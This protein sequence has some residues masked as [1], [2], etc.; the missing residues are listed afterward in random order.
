MTGQPV[1][2][3]PPR[4]PELDADYEIVRE[5]GRGGTAVVYLARERGPGREVAIKVIR[6]TYVEDEE[7]RARLLREA[8]T[9]AALEHPNV[10][11]LYGTRHLRDGSIA[12]VMQ[13]VPGF[14]LRSELRRRGA[15]PIDMARGIATDLCRALVHAHAHR[16]VHR[17]VKPE[18]VYVDE[19]TGSARLSDFGIARTWGAESNLT[20]PGTAIGTPAYMSPE[21]IDGGVLDGRSDIYSLGLLAYEM[22]TGQAP[23]AGESLF[24]AIYKQKHEDLPAI[25]RLR[26]ETPAEL[27]AAIERALQKD[28][29]SRW[30]NAEE[31]LAALDGS[32]AVVSAA[33]AAAST[34]RRAGGSRRKRR[35]RRSG[36][37][38]TTRSQAAPSGAPAA[39]APANEAPT[40]E[41]TAGGAPAG[42]APGN[43]APG[44]RKAPG[45]KKTSRDATAGVLPVPQP[46]HDLQ[47]DPEENLTVWYRRPQAPAEP[48]H[49]SAPA[50]P[51]HES[52][53]APPTRSTPATSPAAAARARS[54]PP[55][56]QPASP[57]AERAPAAAQ[58]S[59]VKGVRFA[60]LRA[61]A[62]PERRAVAA[63]AAVLAAAMAASPAMVSFGRWHPGPASAEQTA[64][65]AALQPGLPAAAQ[66]AAGPPGA[67]A[68]AY[69]V[70]GDGQAGPVG[71]TLSDPLVLRVEDASG[72]PV[73]GAT[74]RFSVVTG[75]AV[76]EPRTAITDE[77]GV[78]MARWLPA[79]PGRHAV[80]ATVDGYDGAPATF[81]AT[82]FAG[83]SLRISAAAD[84]E[85]RGA[86]GEQV[87]PPLQVRVADERGEPVAGVPVRFSVVRGDGR[88]T[89]DVEV[90][91]ADGIARAAWV[92]GSAAAQ[93]ATASLRD[94]PGEQVVF[95][96]AASGGALAVRSGFALGG[97][98]T[99]ALDGRGV[100]VCWGGNDNGQLGDGSGARRAQPVQVSA[101][102]RFAVLAAGVSHTCAIGVS[103]A[104][105]CWGS[106]AAGQLGDGTRTGSSGPARV[107]LAEPLAG[108]FAG[109]S[110]SCGLQE[111]GRLYCWGQ[112]AHGQLGDG[113]RTDR[114]T[115]VR[116]GRGGVFRTAALGWAHTCALTPAGAAFC[117]GRNTS[118]ELGDGRSPDR[119]E[120]APVAGDHRFT[121]IAAGSAHTCALRTD[122][123]VLC[124]GQNSHGQ[125]GNGTTAN[126]AVPVRVQ[127][128]ERF[129]AVAA[130]GVHSCALTRSGEVRC[131]G[132]NVYGQL[133]DGTNQDRHQPVAVEGVSGLTTLDAS[134]AHTCAS[135]GGARYCWGF[136]LAGQLGDGTRANQN[137][138]VRQR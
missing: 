100:A 121:A 60:E 117:W 43:K 98:H 69:V 120:P 77:S 101:P 57:A 28:P 49:E 75:E 1:Y 40:N 41:S 31:F 51:A 2:Y 105:F 71:D 80:R 22:L 81:T 20:L 47:P 114:S 110:H 103:G 79:V 129:A 14:T 104:A 96:A 44:R 26:P 78:A 56:S 3:D 45:K 72:R 132:R 27:T 87:Q 113:S 42:E 5:L 131:W 29:A 135:G 137:R 88:V 62:R 125:L 25:S 64:A 86:A 11:M 17:D 92:L 37:Y 6:S 58:A 61:S 93:E 115:P 54:A 134:G 123:A 32:A 136:N 19:A 30:A 124:W 4:I 33:P 108:V 111:S 73:S 122:G 84:A 74:V 52:A 94:A 76:V 83:G 95:R 128:D 53:P 7:A 16:I 36:A 38:T 85:R 82:A 106:N 119:A 133:G 70:Y 118:G 34:G 91:G 50:E 21:Q 138:P 68:L 97:T 89:P 24:G 107:A 109:M 102:E 9:V 65:A 46:A 112:N 8:R 67:P 18:N 35:G 15:L 63:I 39:A 13:Y 48:T 59:A 90:T 10:V 130:G 55:P 23:W 116:A 126:S 66:T 127:S 99:C 12:L